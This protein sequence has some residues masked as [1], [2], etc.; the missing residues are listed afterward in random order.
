MMGTLIIG[1]VIIS[2]FCTL[3]YL[4]DRDGVGIYDPDPRPRHKQH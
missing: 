4:E 3:F 2:T 1:A